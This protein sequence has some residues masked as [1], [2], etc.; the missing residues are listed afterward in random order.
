MRLGLI[1]NDNRTEAGEF[2][3]RIA[4][5]A[6]DL[7]IECTSDHAPLGLP[8]LGTPDILVAVGGDGTVLEAVG[9]GLLLDRP[10]VGFN[11]GTL[12]FL[13]EAEP[14]DLVPVLERLMKGDYSIVERPTLRAQLDGVAEA[15]VNDVVIEKIDSQRLVVLDVLV[16]GNPFLTYRA[17]GIVFATTTGST[18]YAFSAGGPLVDPLVEAIL[19]VPVAPHSL[20]GRP[21]I[22]PPTALVECRVAANRPVRVSVDGRQVGTLGVENSLHISTGDQRSQFIILDEEP[23]TSRLTRKFGLS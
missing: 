2:A 11:L 4:G 9:T 22:L 8:A 7:G 3:T 5:V 14:E 16:D 6:D 13:A 12:G 17:D 19:M 10:L 23:F 18:A 21:V 20:F 1:V 15:G